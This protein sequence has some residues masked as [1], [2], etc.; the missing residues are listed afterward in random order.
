MFKKFL[1]GNLEAAEEHG[2]KNQQVDMVGVAA[3][4]S[5]HVGE[6]SDFMGGRR[7]LKDHAHH[8]PKDLADEVINGVETIIQIRREIGR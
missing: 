4:L 2:N 3:R 7:K 1:K 8:D 6:L 5:Q